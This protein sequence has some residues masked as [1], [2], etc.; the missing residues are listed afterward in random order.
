MNQLQLTSEK[1]KSHPLT[2]KLLEWARGHRGSLLCIALPA[3][4]ATFYFSLI[5][6]DLYASEARYVVQSPSQ[7][8][9]SG[10]AGFLGGSGFGRGGEDAYSVRDFILS[11]DAVA[12][13][14]KKIDLRAMF[15]RPEADY[16]SQ[17]PRFFESD[18]REDFYRY[19]LRH[20]EVNYDTATGISTLT[21]KAFRA[22]DA[23]KIAALLLDASEDVVNRMN[24]R[25]RTNT[26]RD[27]DDQVQVAE[28]HV[29]EAEHNMLVYRRGETLLDPNK[30]SGA[31]FD[32][33]SKMQTELASL[34]LRRAELE[35]NLPD[36][37]LLPDVKQQV[38]ALERQIGGQNSK[39]AGG[40]GSMAPKIAAYEQLQLRQEFAAKE[41]TSALASLEAARAEARHQQIYLGR[42]V[43][44]NLPDKALYPK[45][46][47]AI[48]IVS[49]TCFLIYSIAFLL[50]AGVREH[51]QH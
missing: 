39:L 11:R 16:F 36:S 38:D 31:M 32:T 12:T 24:D 22:D 15:H 7:M 17:F 43:E 13:L 5:A 14:Q 3:F 35:R 34:Q 41:L 47:E 30:T 45:R 26:I 27:A 20:V 28:K 25:A 51:A 10:L 19:Y 6:A 48:L 1:L 21:V 4:I 29:T 8:P 50:I 44:A 46:L 49:I 42:V 33:L 23:Q 18:S 9:V 2:I 37:P 40:K